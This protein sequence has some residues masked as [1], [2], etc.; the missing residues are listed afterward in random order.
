MLIRRDIVRREVLR[1][2]QR[3]YRFM[4]LQAS[5]ASGFSSRAAGKIAEGIN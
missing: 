4:Q 1:Q 2:Q 5:L 3:L